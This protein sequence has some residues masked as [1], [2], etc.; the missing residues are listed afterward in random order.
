MTPIPLLLLGAALILGCTESARLA[1]P[2]DTPDPPAF[3]A[4]DDAISRLLPA[5]A[6]GGETAALAAR[7]VALRSHL[8]NPVP[9]TLEAA[10]GAALAALDEY[11]AGAEPGF[12]PDADAVELAVLAVTTR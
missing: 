5:L 9:A 1:A 10:K 8:D 12:H 3:T 4:L 7:L 11:R 6:E 2:P